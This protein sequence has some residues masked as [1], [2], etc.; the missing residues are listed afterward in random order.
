MADTDDCQRLKGL[1]QM[2]LEEALA[3]L[4]A[5]KTRGEFEDALNDIRQVLDE[6]KQ[7]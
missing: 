1:L 6:F 3:R 5:A 2:K 7:C 4:R